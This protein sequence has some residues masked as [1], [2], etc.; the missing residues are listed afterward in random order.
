MCRSN[1][2]EMYGNVNSYLSYC[3][4]KKSTVFITDLLH[5]VQNHEALQVL[6]IIYMSGLSCFLTW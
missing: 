6:D 1:C 5:V 3:I 4:L 2:N